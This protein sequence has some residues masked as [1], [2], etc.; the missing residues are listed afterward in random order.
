MG[1]V[2]ATLGI[3]LR[4]TIPIRAATIYP[5]DMCRINTDVPVLPLTVSLALGKHEEG[6]GC[7][8]SAPA[9]YPSVCGCKKK[10]ANVCERCKVS[11]ACPSR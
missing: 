4:V 7:S 1:T 2:L 10:A 9:P 3:S 6:Y 5:D 11:Q 8:G